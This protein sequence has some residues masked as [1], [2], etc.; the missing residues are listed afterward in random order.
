MRCAIQRLE[1]GLDQ[2]GDATSKAISKVCA[3][4]ATKGN[5]GSF[6]SIVRHA[7]RSSLRMTT[8]I[9]AALGKVIVDPL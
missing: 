7:G 6:D 2:T 1:A 9:G 8:W 4:R 3:H 5:R